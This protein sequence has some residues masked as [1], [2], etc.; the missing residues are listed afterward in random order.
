M[1]KV[2]HS[3]HTSHFLYKTLCALRSELTRSAG[4]H[5]LLYEIGTPELF[6]G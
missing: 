2:I 5:N 6:S 1:K 3:I 4:E